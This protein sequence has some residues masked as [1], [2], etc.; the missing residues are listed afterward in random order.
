MFSKVILVL[1]LTT[2]VAL[3]FST[4]LEAKHQPKKIIII[5]PPVPPDKTEKCL[6]NCKVR[7]GGDRRN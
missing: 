5:Q 6:E 3:P 2:A 7:H 1:F 4:I